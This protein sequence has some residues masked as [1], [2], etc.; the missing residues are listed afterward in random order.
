MGICLRYAKDQLEAEDILQDGFVKIYTNIHRY[1]PFGSFEGWMKRIFINTA[2]EYYRQR[3]KFLISEIEIE[4]EEFEIKEDVVDKMAAEEILEL[5]K[6]L[7]DGYRMVFNMYAI[8]GYSHK[9][10]AEELNISVGTSK[11]QY[12]RARNYFQQLLKNQEKTKL[13]KKYADYG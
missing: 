9:E 7:P 13:G 3:K 6:E 5:M 8:E 4:N 10:I 1:K 12:S 2:I 11:S